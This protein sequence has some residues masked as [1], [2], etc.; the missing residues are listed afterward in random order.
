MDIAP[1]VLAALGTPVARYMPGRILEEIFVK[2]PVAE[3]VESYLPM[4]TSRPKATPRAELL[5]EV[6]ERLR[7]L[8]YLDDE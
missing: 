5:P 3:Y 1:T 6:R 4:P 7:S 8:G 2:P